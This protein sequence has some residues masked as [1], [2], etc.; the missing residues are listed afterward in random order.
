MSLISFRELSILAIGL[1][2][3]DVGSKFIN[4]S[5]S[6]STYIDTLNRNFPQKQGL[7]KK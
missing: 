7:Q 6:N 5:Q 3:V 4:F 1:S 2:R